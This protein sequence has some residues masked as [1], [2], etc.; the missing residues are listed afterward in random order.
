MLWTRI[1]TA[2]ILVPLAVLAC[3]YLP[4]EYFSLFM[5]LVFLLA[6]WEWAAL[7]GIKQSALR[8]L[9]ILCFAVGLY[10]FYSM[11]SWRYV[12]TDISA[13]LWVG[14][15]VLLCWVI[16]SKALPKCHAA[17]RMLLGWL[18]LW[19]AFSA[20]LLLKMSVWGGKGVLLAC[21]IVWVSDSAAYF[22]GRAFGKR[23][24]APLIS[25][26][27]TWEGFF[28]GL[29]VA[30]LAASFYLFYLPL[31]PLHA[32][33]WV[34]LVVIVSVITVTGDLFESVLKRLAKVK[35]SGALLPGHGGIL[36]RLDGFIAALPVF[37]LLVSIAHLL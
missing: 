27:K 12:I 22:V 29:L 23:K 24:L 5:G 21:I 31:I 7:A 9:Y 30:L 18:L 1:L 10:V 36:D 32:V 26:G 33:S 13:F 20:V 2:I 15:F 28:G 35:D 37:V 34:V 16:V 17:F 19:G 4:V 3:L 25:P 8:W 6:A 14:I 11:Q